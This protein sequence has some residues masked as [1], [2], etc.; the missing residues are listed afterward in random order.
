MNEIHMIDRRRD[1]DV[2]A[3][4]GG[5]D[6]AGEIDDVHDFAAEQIAEPVGVV[7]QSEFRIL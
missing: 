7:G 4:P 2:T 3:M 5:R 1:H 6:G